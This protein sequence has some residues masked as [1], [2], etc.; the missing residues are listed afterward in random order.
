MYRSYQ[1]SNKGECDSEKSFIR[2][3]P[4]LKKS[5]D[6]RLVSIENEIENLAAC[7]KFNMLL[8]NGDEMYVH[9]NKKGTLYMYE[10]EGLTLFST[11]P[12][13]K[14][15]DQGRWKA[16]PLNRLLVYKQGVKVYEGKEHFY[17]S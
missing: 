4:L 9:S 14:V 1:K 2:L 11:K 5:K 10:G 12:L 8:T 7:G 16:V 13:E 17:A 15:R 3:I 6:K